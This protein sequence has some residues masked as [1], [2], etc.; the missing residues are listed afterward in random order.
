ML[1]FFE[2]QLRSFDLVY[3]DN[4]TVLRVVWR[5][6]LSNVCNYKSKNQPGKQ[7]PTHV[8]LLD[9]CTCLFGDQVMN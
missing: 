9:N 1:T 8:S 3:E 5:F 4:W 6:P 2:Y 7:S